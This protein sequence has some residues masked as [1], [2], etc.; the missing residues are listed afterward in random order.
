MFMRSSPKLSTSD[1]PMK[2]NSAIFP[3]RKTLLDFVSEKLD[4]KVV[5]KLGESPERWLEELDIINTI[6]VGEGLSCMIG[7]YQPPVN[8]EA[9]VKIGKN[10]FLYSGKDIRSR[11]LWLSRE[12]KTKVPYT[13]WTRYRLSSNATVA[14]N[15]EYP[16]LDPAE[17]LPEKFEPGSTKVKEDKRPILKFPLVLNGKKR[18]VYAKGSVVMPSYLTCPPSYRLTSL[19]NCAVLTSFR[20]MEVSLNLSKKGVRVPPIVGYYEGPFEEFLFLGSVD[21]GN[22]LSYL[23]SCSEQI[24]EQDAAM[25]AAL[26]LSGYHKIGFTDFEDKV[27]DGQNLHLIDTEEFGDLYRFLGVEYRKI[28]LDPVD[29]VGLEGFRELQ[30]GL[31]RKELRDAIFM[32]RETFLRSIDSRILYAKSFYK[33]LGLGEP[34]EEELRELTDFPSDYMTADR[35][36]SMMSDC[37]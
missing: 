2:F 9:F 22:P 33:S 35:E 18:E 8:D 4:K 11:G 25:L 15:E 28:L 6:V 1:I 23:S 29:K 3:A 30:L 26:C 17:L 12:V 16:N 14:V 36:I 20:E 37:D 32:Y 21:G 7:M 5:Q 10:A 31:F 34:V 24:I 19:S 27:F 13:E